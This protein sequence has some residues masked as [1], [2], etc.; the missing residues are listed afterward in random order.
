MP[1]FII[2]ND[3]IIFLNIP[4]NKNKKG[5]ANPSYYTCYSIKSGSKAAA[6]D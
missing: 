3:V 4:K 2:K 5:G 1:L 6:I